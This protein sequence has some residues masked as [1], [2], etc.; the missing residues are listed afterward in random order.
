[1]S[2]SLKQLMGYSQIN[3][4][5][6]LPT[7]S[8]IMSIG[9]RPMRQGEEEA[10][11]NMLRKLPRDLGYDMV[12]KI[13]AQSLRDNADLVHVTVALDSG[14]LLG[15]C[16]WLMTYSSNRGCKGV[17]ICDL[18]VMEHKRGCGIGEKMLRATGK[19]A[20]KLGAQFIKLEAS[21]E[22]PKPGKF[23]MKHN[24]HFV[25]DDRL[26][27]LEPEHFTSFLEGKAI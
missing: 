7:E 10:V 22:N 11:A 19:T 16:T 20:A 13:T 14:L 21:R 9:C 5:C 4:N 27:F 12:P 6:S 1:M 2:C 26:M 23:Y 17:Y 25:D 8:P 3:G 18:Y 15:A 24:F